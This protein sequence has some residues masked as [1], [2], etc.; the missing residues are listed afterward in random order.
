MCGIFGIFEEEKNKDNL[1]YDLGSLSESRGK[2]ASGLMVLDG[3][4][5][6]IKKYSNKF[7]NNRV[8]EF[9][10]AQKFTKNAKYFGH[11]RLETSGSNKDNLNNQPV[12]TE[13]VIVLHNGIITNYQEIN[14]KFN[15]KKNLDLD[16]FVINELIE[17]YIT[18]NSILETMANVFYELEG[19][20]SLLIYFK[21]EKKF[22][23]YT[24]TGS[25]YYTSNETKIKLFSSEE[26]I[27]K[28]FSSNLKVNQIKPFTGVLLNDNSEIEEIFKFELEGINRQKTIE[29]IREDLVSESYLQPV[30]NRCSKCI[31]PSTFPYIDFDEK[32]ICNICNNYEKYKL[33][34]IEEINQEIDKYENL[35]IG[36]SGGRDSSYG[37]Y[38]IDKLYN[39]N[40]I[41]ASYDWGMVTDLARRNQ[42]RVCGKL[43][44]E[45]IWISADIQEKR[46]NIKKNLL[47]WLNKPHIGMLPI[48]MAGDKVWQKKLRKTAK[49]KDKSCILQFQSPYEATFFK[50]GFAGIKPDFPKMKTISKAK[51]FIFYLY[52]FIINY[53]YWNWSL[54]D[55]FLGFFSFY[56]RKSAFIYPYKYYKF[57]ESLIEEELSEKLN[58]EFDETTGT[59]WRIGDGTAPF[60]N[61]VYWLYAGFT[62]NDSFRSYQIREGVITRE[63]AL[64]IIKLENIPRFKRIKEYLDLI[65]LDYDF[66]MNELEKIKKNSLVK[67]WSNY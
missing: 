13:R 44:I 3:P 33:L 54:L 31:L 62:E 55:S 38:L 10:R 47:A 50:H 66:V 2:E 51:L 45:H 65:D 64:R 14:K 35:I 37:V 30:L 28:K 60:Y 53:K 56:F 24:N 16:S 20:A 29:Q 26:W 48:L 57:D 7:R 5:L 6:V 15:F 17:H 22:L 11:T 39:K 61:Y 43:G 1:F 23:I 4:E 27:T 18:N 8:K 58:W 25:I 21:N 52:N 32:G 12:E 36:F 40:I 34:N 9:L 42:A 63:E 67:E 46:K 59:S 41:A 19:E 49:L